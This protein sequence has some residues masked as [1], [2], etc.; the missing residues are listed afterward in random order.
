MKRRFLIFGCFVL[1]IAL[2]TPV[3]AV[4]ADDDDEDDEGDD[5]PWGEAAIDHKLNV[6][7]Q[8]PSEYVHRPLVY[9]KRVVEFGV[10]LDYKYTHHYWDDSGNL[11]AGSFKTKKETLNIFL[12]GGISDW[13]SASINWPLTYRKTRVFKG[14]QNYVRSSKNT[15][16]TLGEQAVVDFLDH[17][18]PWKL[19]EMDLPTMGDVDLWIAISLFR[20]LDPTTNIIL[21]TNAKFATGNDNPRRAGEIRGYMTSGQTDFYSGFAVKQSVWQMG[22]ELHAGYNYRLPADTK[23]SP[24]HLDLA[25]QVKVDGEIAIQVPAVPVLP[26]WLVFGTDWAAAVEAHYMM[27]VAESTVVDALDNEIKLQ[28]YPGYNLSVTP[29]IVL[30]WGP[31]TDMI[32]SADIPVQGQNSFLVYSRSYYLPPFDIEGN[33]GVGVT[34]TLGLKKRWQ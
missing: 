21:E 29:K 28:D 22:F 3:L 9:S 24:G 15:Y 13:L 7:F 34:Y 23:F 31:M 1:V 32:L 16:G 8:Y 11:V 4:A 26:K 33:D 5:N 10:V 2:M 19:W 14:N 25:D 6:G 30:A 18:D 12:G 27:R 20:R 17:S